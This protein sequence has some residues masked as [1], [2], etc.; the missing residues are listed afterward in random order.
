MRKKLGRGV[1]P[2]PISMVDEPS[3]QVN[4]SV[5]SL[6]TSAAMM[7]QLNALG[8]SASVE[9]KVVTAVRPWSRLTRGERKIASSVRALSSPAVT[10]FCAIAPES[11]FPAAASAAR[12]TRR[13]RCA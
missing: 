12:S 4:P 7:L 10:P 6:D 5:P 9:R 11:A 13:S 2:V 1:G 3:P 8:A